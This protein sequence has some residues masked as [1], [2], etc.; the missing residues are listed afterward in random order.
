MFPCI[1]CSP[2]GAISIT[3]VGLGILDQVARKVQRLTLAVS[4]GGDLGVCRLVP[5]SVA[6][7]VASVPQT[8]RLRAS[9]NRRRSGLTT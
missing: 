4:L 5:M 9:R 7:V 3:A 2:I 1:A 6:P 8:P